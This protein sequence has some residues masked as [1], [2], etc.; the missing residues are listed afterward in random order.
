[1]ASRGASGHTTTFNDCPTRHCLW[2]V[3]TTDSTISDTATTA[4]SS[5]ASSG[6]SG[7]LSAAAGIDLDV[8]AFLGKYGR[9]FVIS[10][11]FSCALP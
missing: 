3:P 1:M 11:G 9:F 5:S 10:C 7:L 8:I 6:D 4:D 2:T